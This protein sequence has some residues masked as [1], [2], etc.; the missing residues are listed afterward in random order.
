MRGIKRLRRNMNDR[1][2]SLLRLIDSKYQMS[3]SDAARGSALYQYVSFL[4]PNLLLC[5]GDAR[6]IFLYVH[7]NL[8]LRHRV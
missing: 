1:M 6:D 4:C 3:R 8:N 7:V 2:A 5:L